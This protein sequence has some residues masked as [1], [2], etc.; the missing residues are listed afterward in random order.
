MKVYISFFLKI[1]YHLVCLTT[2]F[3]FWIT[4]H[5]SQWCIEMLRILQYICY[6]DIV[7]RSTEPLL[8]LSSFSMVCPQVLM[9]CQPNLPNLTLLA[10]S[11]TQTQVNTA[12]FGITRTRLVPNTHNIN[13]RTELTKGT[14]EAS[15]R[16]ME[17]NRRLGARVFF[18]IFHPSVCSLLLTFLRFFPSFSPFGVLRGGPELQTA[19]RMRWG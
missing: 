13:K 18:D 2:F 6:A 17:R 1:K 10:V 9:V 14:G 12:A 19:G 8:L 15:D 3:H 16:W 5:E 4:H 7:C 11:T